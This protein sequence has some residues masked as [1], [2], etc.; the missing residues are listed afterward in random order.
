MQQSTKKKRPLRAIVAALLIIVLTVIG[1]SVFAE[2]STSGFRFSLSDDGTYYIVEG[3]DESAAVED[4]VLEIPSK[5]K[6]LPVKAIGDFEKWDM[7]EVV[8]PDSITK[9]ETYAFRNCENL[10]TVILPENI[11]SVGSAFYGCTALTYNTHDNAYYLG[12]ETNPYLCLVRTKNKGVTSCAIHQDTK[13]IAGTAFYESSI[14]KLTIPEGVQ[15]V[16]YAAFEKCTRLTALELPNSLKTIDFSF[17]DLCTSLTYREYD[18]GKYL[19]NPQNPNLF[20]VGARN[21]NITHCTI[22]QNTKFIGKFAF[23][24]CQK[25]TRVSI[26][27]TVEQAGSGVFSLCTSLESVTL[28]KN[29]TKMGNYFFDRCTALRQIT[30]PENLERIG[31]NAFYSCTALTELTIP[32]KVK[33]INGAA[34][35]GCK[36][37]TSVTFIEPNGWSDTGDEVSFNDPSTAA[38]ILTD[39]ISS[40]GAWTRES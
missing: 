20:F 21:E 8:I 22:R 3:L 34:F 40:M 36:N 17:I 10:E 13:I 18:N 14:K 28:P 7:K 11:V 38:K 6:R 19:G 5:Y 33:Y 2:C 27:D 9:I 39:F 23:S 12:S 37:L 26:P 32:A 30:L 31:E 1:V 35:D 25:L 16:G 24:E 4:G 29:M 15:T